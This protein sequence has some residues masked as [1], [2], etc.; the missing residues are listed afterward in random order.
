M[1][2][3]SHTKGRWLLDGKLVYAL[4][5]DGVNIFSTLIQGGLTDNSEKT[6]D[7]EL[8]ANARVIASAPELLAACQAQHEAIDRL[9][10][11]LI[12]LSPRDKTFY[13][14]K[15]GQPWEAAVAGNSAI[16]KAT[17]FS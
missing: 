9:F 7:A 10:A 11:M 14:S 13:P 8:F 5:V 6:R 3:T 17:G 12:D 2:I 16:A 15:S 4:N 1:T